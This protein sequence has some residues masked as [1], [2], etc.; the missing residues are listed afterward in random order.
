MFFGKT[1]FSELFRTFEEREYVFLC[2]ETAS[3]R[4][5]Q[6]IAEVTDDLIGNKIADRITNISTK[7]RHNNSEI[8]TNEEGWY[9]SRKKIRQIIND[10]RLI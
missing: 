1:I 2:R 8:V 4:A 9:I 3:K 10:L 6:K 7:L 5:I